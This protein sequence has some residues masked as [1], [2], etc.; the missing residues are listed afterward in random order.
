MAV[1]SHTSTNHV[2]GFPS[3]HTLSSVYCFILVILKWELSCLPGNTCHVWRCFGPSQWGWGCCWHL[4][5]AAKHPNDAQ[6]RTISP[7]VNGTEVEKP[8]L[9]LGETVPISFAFQAVPKVV[10][11]NPRPHTRLSSSGGSLSLPDTADALGS[12]L[13]P[14]F[15]LFFFFWK[16]FFL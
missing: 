10:Q 6:D 5:V 9:H 1:P 4:V 12:R 14:L 8:W 16:I 15:L 13:P 3:L 2:G 7:R 11:M